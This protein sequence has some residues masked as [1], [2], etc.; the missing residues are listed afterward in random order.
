MFFGS[1]FSISISLSLSLIF[2]FHFFFFFFF[3][4]VNCQLSWLYIIL[5]QAPR[6]LSA[7]IEIAAICDIQE[8]GEHTFAILSDRNKEKDRR[9]RERERRRRARGGQDETSHLAESQVSEE[10]T[11]RRDPARRGNLHAALACML[12]TQMIKQSRF[13]DCSLLLQ[14]PDMTR[15]A[16]TALSSCPSRLPEDL[17]MRS[18]RRGRRGKEEEGGGGGGEGG[19]KEEE[20]EK[21]TER[22]KT[23]FRDLVD[24]ERDAWK[25]A[26]SVLV[27]DQDDGSGDTTGMGSSVAS[28]CREIVERRW[29]RWTRTLRS[30]LS[31]SATDR[32]RAWCSSLPSLV[33]SIA[34]LQCYRHAPQEREEEEEEKLGMNNSHPGSGSSRRSG[35]RLTEGERENGRWVVP[36]GSRCE[37]TLAFSY[38]RPSP[39]RHL[40][41]RDLAW[42]AVIGDPVSGSLY[43]MKRMTGIGTQHRGRGNDQRISHGGG[44]RSE[45]RESLR[46][47]APQRG[48]MKKKDDRNVE[49]RVFLVCNAVS[50][51]DRSVALPL[52]LDLRR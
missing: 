39:T 31:A 52:T 24:V 11:V 46:F 28:L 19:E 15:R 49:L 18:E 47:L 9:K 12:L 29:E 26:Q 8:E 45:G 7:M 3:F 23:T 6:V 21:V 38:S 4:F 35:R 33:V 5:Q 36:A 10:K 25:Q 32:V 50:G 43:S 17:M 20:K 40:L 30:F 37:L 42:W 48:A 13:F 16:A 34:S 44:R 14:P 51:L 2:F 1:P 22:M 27:D 41:P